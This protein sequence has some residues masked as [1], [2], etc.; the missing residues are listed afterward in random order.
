MSVYNKTGYQ[1][2]SRKDMGGSP[3]EGVLKDS[4]KKGKEE[5]DVHLFQVETFLNC[6]KGC[7]I[8]T[9]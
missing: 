6:R 9:F 1:L 5:G 3:R 7:H 2:E 4:W 8:D